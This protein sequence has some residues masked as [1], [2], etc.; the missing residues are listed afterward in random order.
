MTVSRA[1]RAERAVDAALR[2]GIKVPERVAIAGFNDLAG[3]DQMLPALTTV[4][5]PRAEIGS[6][7]ARMLLQL[8]PQEVVAPPC[9]NVG[10]ELVVR[11]S[12]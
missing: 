6:A 5:T 11:A 3:S 8:M 4:R 7:A 12:T 9:V 2:L 1:L 10:Y